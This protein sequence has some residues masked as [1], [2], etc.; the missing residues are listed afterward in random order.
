MKSR[1]LGLPVLVFG[2]VVMAV[3]IS[4][5]ADGPQQPP[6]APLALIPERA[7]IMRH[8]F[9]DVSRIHEAV[10]RGD[11]EA[12]REPARRLGQ[13]PVPAGVPEAG[14]RYV[15]TMRKS[16]ERVAAAKTVAVAATETVIMLNQCAGCHQA[17]GIRPT[18]P[19][20]STPDVGGLVGHMLEHQ[21]AAD[22]LLQGLVIPSTSEWQSGATR[23]GTVPLRPVWLV[24]ELR[25]V[26]DLDKVDAA[27]HDLAA[28]ALSADNPTRRSAAYVRL[29][30]TCAECHSLHTKIWGPDRRGR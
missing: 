16:G 3:S 27:V 1:R 26:P 4:A 10:I 20:Q 15:V 14:L 25:Y 11:L 9:A 12:V 24:P 5:R 22:A 21:R 2:A 28:E 29:L 8:H 19:S 23:L 17:V 13:L 18:P 7:A 6:A 30:T